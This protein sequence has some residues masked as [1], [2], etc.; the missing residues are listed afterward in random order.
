MNKN[1]TVNAFAF[2]LSPYAP[3]N[4]ETKSYILSNSDKHTGCFK[5]VVFFERPV[6]QLLVG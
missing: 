6:S 2:K 5:L 1:Q 3:F 4:N